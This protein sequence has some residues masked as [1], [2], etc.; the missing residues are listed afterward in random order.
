MLN[1]AMKAVSI[2]WFVLFLINPGHAESLKGDVGHSEKYGSGWLDL[3]EKAN[4]K[5]GER[6]RI[7]VGGTA[8]YVLV[9]LLPEGADPN[10]PAGILGG[11]V[12]VPDSRLIELAVGE[13]RT[14]VVQISVHGGPGPFGMPVPENNGPARVLRIEHIDD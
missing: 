3:K 5:K 6:I 10:G 13:E 7:L 12:Q 11:V 4:F 9:R 2:V 8:K 14:G 1:A